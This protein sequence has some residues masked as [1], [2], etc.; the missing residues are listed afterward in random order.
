MRPDKLICQ[1]GSFSRLSQEGLLLVYGLPSAHLEPGHGGKQAT[2]EA[3]GTRRTQRS[4]RATHCGIVGHSDISRITQQPQCP[5]AA[6]SVAAPLSRFTSGLARPP[7]ARKADPPATSPTFP[8]Y[9]RGPSYMR[10]R[11]TQ[12]HFHRCASA[13]GTCEQQGPDVKG[14]RETMCMGLSVGYARP[15]EC[16]LERSR[17]D[18]S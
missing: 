12:P 13:L 17:G 7:S 2:A 18:K 3:R 10:G 11:S 14:L 15:A 4:K 9:R 16:A 6:E 8:R 1:S 5:M